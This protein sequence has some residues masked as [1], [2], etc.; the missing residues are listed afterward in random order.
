MSRPIQWFRFYVEALDDPKVQRLSPPLFK[1]WVNLL[2]LAAPTNGELPS[3]DDIAFKLRLSTHDTQQVL[4]ELTLCGLIDVVRAMK[5]D[6]TQ[7]KRKMHNW[8]TRQYKSDT[9]TER[10][11]RYR[12]KQSTEKRNTDETF[13]ETPPETETETE[14]E[15]H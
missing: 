5:R 15:E 13:L 9:S 10:V 6:E 2:C 12:K 4:D 3:A 14:A 1:C 8:D 7:M 11:R